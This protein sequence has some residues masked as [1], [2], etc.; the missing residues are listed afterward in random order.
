ME[1]LAQ[2]HSNLYRLR[3]LYNIIGQDIFAASGYRRHKIFYVFVVL[4]SLMIASYVL[5]LL[6]TSDLPR[7]SR[8]CQT[9]VL[10]GASEVLWKFVFLSDW[11]MLRTI[12][13]YFEKFYRENS[14]PTDK[15]YAVARRFVR[16]TERGL[17]F[18]FFI[19]TGLL[20]INLLLAIYDS[21]RTGEPMLFLYVPFVREY[22]CIQLLL[23]NI[24]V[25]IVNLVVAVAEPAG[26]A[27][28]YVI[29]VSLTTIP[30]VIASQMDELTQMLQQRSVSVVEIKQRWMH[31]IGLHHH[32]NE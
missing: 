17:K 26:D 8:V 5:D 2:Y 1:N 24:Y 14:R 4:L 19:Y 9:A 18:A 21:F 25:A 32:F 22:T 20:L 27:L 10:L 3:R 16:L 31:F 29:L 13:D 11:T 23:L 28:I 6:F 30:E 15:Y 12:I 7:T